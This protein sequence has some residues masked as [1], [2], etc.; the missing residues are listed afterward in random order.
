MKYK[1]Q[2][3]EVFNKWLGRQKD[4]ATRRK[5]FARLARAENGNFGDHKQLGSALFE[6]RLFFSG[7]LRI[8]YTIRERRIV[9]LLA[10]G[11]KGSQTADIAK[12][13]Q[14]LN[15]LE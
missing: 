8:Y 13:E 14:M 10:G 1:L 4:A 7:G 15:E 12:A 6:L 3:S 5:I 9:F 11:D 2:G